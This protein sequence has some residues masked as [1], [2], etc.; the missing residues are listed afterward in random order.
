MTLESATHLVNELRASLTEDTGEE[1]NDPIPRP[2]TVMETALVVGRLEG[3]NEEID[4]ASYE[5]MRT[6]EPRCNPTETV[7]GSMIPAP[8]EVRQTIEEPEI[9][10]V[11]THAESPIL[12][13]RPSIEETPEFRAKT[14]IPTLP[15]LGELGRCTE[16]ESGASNENTP[17]KMSLLI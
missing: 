3:K 15:E 17:V 4:N 6:E 8:L 1:S 13:A 11:E 2:I 5:T 7:A 10:A 14:V 16:T 9:H 12:T